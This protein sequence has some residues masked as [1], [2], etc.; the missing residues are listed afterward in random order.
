M[1]PHDYACITLVDH[2]GRTLLDFVKEKPDRDWCIRD[3]IPQHNEALK[4]G[5]RDYAPWRLKRLPDGRERIDV[6]GP[7]L[8]WDE[9]TRGA[10]DRLWASGIVRQLT[11]EEL[12]FSINST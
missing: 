10:L 3:F 11:V 1:R 6:P 12:R 5:K 4:A 2:R 8:Q 9:R 7:L